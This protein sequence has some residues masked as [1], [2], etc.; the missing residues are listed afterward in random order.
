NA[1]VTSGVSICRNGSSRWERARTR[2]GALPQVLADR[3]AT[4]SARPLRTS[5]T[6]SLQTFAV[7][8]DR[9]TSL[10]SVETTPEYPCHFSIGNFRVSHFA[11]CTDDLRLHGPWTL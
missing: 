7:G 10:M 4:R 5:M 2:R 3:A 1:F 8:S 11:D 9:R 6:D